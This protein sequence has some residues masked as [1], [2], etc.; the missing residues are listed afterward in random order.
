LSALNNEERL[1]AAQAA[2]Q[3]IDG[4][5]IL[6]IGSGRAIAKFIEDLSLKI[7]EKEIRIK[8]VPTSI[9]TE[10]L[11]IK[12]H[13]PLTNLNEHPSLD[14]DIDGAD[15]VEQGSLNMIKGGGGALLREK[16]VASS[17]KKLIILIEESKLSN[18]LDH[19]VPVE[20]L[21]FA[22]GYCMKELKKI[23]TPIIRETSGK[24]GPLITDNGNYII[25]LDIGIIEDPY[26][27]DKTLKSI[28]GIVETG[29][30]LDL[31]DEVI[32]GMRKNTVKVLTK[33][34]N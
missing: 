5:M 29:L 28:P 7:I 21:P 11:C 24:L 25:D 26:N 10:L 4:D 9:Q 15:Q 19:T 32:M 34:H 33:T 18:K 30:F 6:G 12:H 8:A 31:A 16:I 2:V 13:I 17:S 27:T 3:F 23:G 1:A 20:V 14:L 22:L